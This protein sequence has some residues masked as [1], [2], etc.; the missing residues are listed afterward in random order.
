[1]TSMAQAT[2]HESLRVTSVRPRDD[3]VRMSGL[4][5]ASSKAPKHVS[6]G[7]RAPLQFDKAPESTGEPV[8]SILEG[9]G[10]GR[11]MAIRSIRD[12]GG[13]SVVPRPLTFFEEYSDVSIMFR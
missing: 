3:P 11:G 5:M 1:M 10:M 2:N 13:R 12:A 4:S 7:G 6:D 9:E 8:Y